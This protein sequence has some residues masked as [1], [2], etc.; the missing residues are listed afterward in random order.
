MNEI[1]ENKKVNDPAFP[2]SSL[3]KSTF[4]EMDNENVQYSLS[5][6]PNERLAY[7]MELN[8]NAFGKSSLLIEDLGNRIYK[9]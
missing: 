5:L 1:N 6:S 3:R 9:R 4:D 8:I 7:L 2:Y